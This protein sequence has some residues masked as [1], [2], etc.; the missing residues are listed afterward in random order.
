MTYFCGKD[1]DQQENEGDTI[2][3]LDDIEQTPDPNIEESSV[4]RMFTLNHKWLHLYGSWFAT[5]TP[6]KGCALDMAWGLR[7]PISL[8]VV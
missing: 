6:L 5:W 3:Q 1:C 4:E 8:G 2:S 7:W